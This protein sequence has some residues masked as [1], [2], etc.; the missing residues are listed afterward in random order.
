MAVLHSTDAPDTAYDAEV[1]CLT[2]EGARD[3]VSIF[4][5]VCGVI[6]DGVQQ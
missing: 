6:A 3:A 2:D 1:L 5:G 4:D